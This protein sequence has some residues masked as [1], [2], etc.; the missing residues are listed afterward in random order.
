MSGLQARLSTGVLR[1]QS[2]CTVTWVQ[3]TA[4]Q[5]AEMK[6]VKSLQDKLA[7]ELVSLSQRMID[8]QTSKLDSG[9]VRA[10]VITFTI[11]VSFSMHG[12]VC[13]HLV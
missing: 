8:V 6:K 12:N 5:Q 13:C 7:A 4:V 11:C 1:Q 2:D 10:A 9:Q 3:A